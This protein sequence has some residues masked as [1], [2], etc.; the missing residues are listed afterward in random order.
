L[1]PHA[2]GLSVGVCYLS[3]SYSLHVPSCTIIP[4]FALARP[5]S[6]HA[7]STP[8]RLRSFQALA[9]VRTAAAGSKL[10]SRSHLAIAVS[11]TR[12]HLQPQKLANCDERRHVS[13]RRRTILQVAAA[14]EEEFA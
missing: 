13:A 11:T 12:R 1:E 10:R 3:L 14:G 7:P 2:Q 6:G 4:T 5:L 9:V 8:L